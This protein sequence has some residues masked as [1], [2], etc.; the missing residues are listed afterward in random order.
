MNK[1]V[2][3]NPRIC[4]GKPVIVGTR[5]PVSVVLDQMAILGSVENILDLYPELSREQVV[6]TLQYCHSLIEHTEYESLAA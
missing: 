5:I 6:G 1:Y 4:N 3:I 2:Q